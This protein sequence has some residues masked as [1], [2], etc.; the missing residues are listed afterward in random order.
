MKQANGMGSVYKLSG[1]RRKPYVVRITVG[2]EYDK[3]NDKYILKRKIL[4]YYKTQQEARKAL[5]DFNENPCDVNNLEITVKELWQIL[6]PRL[7]KSISVSRMSCYSSAFKYFED[8]EDTPLR[9]IKAKDLQK[10]FDSCKKGSATKDNMKSVISRIYDYAMQNDYVTKDYSQYIT[11][12][13]TPVSIEHYVLTSEDVARLRSRAS[14]WQY[15]LILI[16]LYTGM[17]INEFVSNRA[18]NFDIENRLITIPREIAKNDSSARTVPIHKD[19][20]PLIK[21]FKAVGEEYIAVKPNGYKIVYKN[22]MDREM[23][24][25]QSY[26]GKDFTPHDCRHTFITR[27]HECGLENLVIQRIV[28]HTPDTITE[29]TYTHLSSNELITNIDKYCF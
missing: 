3:A 17:R 28:G 20:I 14:E 7:E 25:I 12:D 22:F 24:E 5:A 16:L 6:S 4:G 21:S 29:H 23:K 10:I 15:A 27:A 11:Y 8:I 13:K 19:I 2:K 18:D 26:L 9:D 1:T